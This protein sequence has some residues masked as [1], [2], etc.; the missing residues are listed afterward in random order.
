MA[1]LRRAQ[2]KKNFFSKLDRTHTEELMRGIIGNTSL[3]I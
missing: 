3:I 1:L 2:E